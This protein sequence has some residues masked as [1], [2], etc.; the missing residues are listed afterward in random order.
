MR[1]RKFHV[2]S[3]F[4]HAMRTQADLERSVLWFN[5]FQAKRIRAFIRRAGLYDVPWIDAVN[6]PSL[7]FPVSPMNRHVRQTF[8]MDRVLTHEFQ[9]ELLFRG[10]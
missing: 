1:Q 3:P 2:V 10:Q 5:E 6:R 4:N 9:M 7:C 8:A